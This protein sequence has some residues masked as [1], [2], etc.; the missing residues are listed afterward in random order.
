M[1]KS[2]I[3]ALLMLLTAS[4]CRVQPEPLSF[5]KDGCHACKM[6]LMDNKFGAEVVTKK[7]KVY[8]FDDLNCLMN[9]LNSNYEPADNIAQ[10]LV[11]DFQNPDQ[12]VDATKAYYIQSDK[13]NSPMASQVAAFS[14]QEDCML[15]NTTWHGTL[16][17]WDNLK[18]L[19]R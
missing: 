15:H 13:I 2:A 3:L 14:T 18:T 5:G 19:F 16:H 4:A 1:P 12:F 7:G 8:K 9:F 6:T 10:Y 11:I 17:N